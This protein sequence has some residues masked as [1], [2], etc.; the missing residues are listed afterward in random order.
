MY[1][2]YW[3][4]QLLERLLLKYESELIASLATLWCYESN[5]ILHRCS[6]HCG[7]VHDAAKIVAC[8]RLFL[9]MDY[10]DD[11]ENQGG[12]ITNQIG[13]RCQQHLESTEP[14]N[15]S[16]EGQHPVGTDSDIHPSPSRGTKAGQQDKVGKNSEESG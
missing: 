8:V 7:Y 13:Q 15:D 12:G 2:N 1:T 3:R 9:D 11:N 6:I 16:P 4:F 5:F 14:R 10:I